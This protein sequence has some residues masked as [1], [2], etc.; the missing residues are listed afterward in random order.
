MNG[1]ST[2]RR[3]TSYF[4]RRRDTIRDGDDD[5]DAGS[6]FYTGGDKKEDKV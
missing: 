5:I 6:D 1:E 4:E 3:W 2:V